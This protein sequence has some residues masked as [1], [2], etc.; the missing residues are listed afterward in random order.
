MPEFEAPSMKRYYETQAPTIWQK[1]LAKAQK[2][3]EEGE[4][5][6]LREMAGYEWAVPW[7]QTGM[8]KRLAEGPS[9]AQLVEGFKSYLK[10]YPWWEKWI[11]KPQR[12]RGEYP[13]TFRPP[14]RWL[15]Y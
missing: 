2:E 6:R 9:E 7:G 11:T 4:Q 5:K 10:E 3:W 15:T 14:T 1:Y 12:E 13:A 8:A